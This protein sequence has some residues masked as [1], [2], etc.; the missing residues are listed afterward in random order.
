MITMYKVF[1]I[2]KEKFLRSFMELSAKKLGFKAFTCEN[3][4]DYLYQFDD[5]KCPV[6]II[7][8]DSCNISKVLEEAKKRDFVKSIYI[9]GENAD[10]EQESA[11]SLPK[12][13][14]AQK[15]LE[16]LKQL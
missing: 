10:I 12:P 16:I 1:Y 7:D 8:K 11:V 3:D 2:E 15:I 4:Q 5:L 9:T 6:L 13:I 14:E